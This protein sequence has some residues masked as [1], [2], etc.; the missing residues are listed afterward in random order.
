[1]KKIASIF[2]AGALVAA[3]GPVA[4]A[5]RP[6]FITP[7]SKI[8]KFE[9]TITNISSLRFTPLLVVAHSDDI[10]LFEAGAEPS[11][12]LADLAESGSTAGLE[13]VLDSVPDSVGD[14]ETTQGLLEPGQSVT[15]MIESTLAMDRLS[16]AAMLLPTNDSFVGL[17][18]VRLPRGARGSITY[19]AIGYDAGSEPN[20]ELCAN[21]PGPPCFGAGGSPDEGGEGYV[22]VSPGI[23]GDADVS[24]RAYDWRNPV[25]RVTVTRVP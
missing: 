6:G 15:V 19:T 5:D 3:L 12:E 13:A 14:V 23:V 20:D 24:A 10:A 9:V 21:I 1:M 4:S 22:R 2:A 25:A 8:G 7:T 18:S 16:L 11:A 17:N